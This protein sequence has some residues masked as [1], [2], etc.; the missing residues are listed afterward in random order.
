MDDFVPANLQHSRDEW[1]ARLVNILTPLLIEGVK[2]IFNEAW[3]MA[4]EN[5][6]AT[7]YLMT[8]QNLLCRVPK[9]NSEIVEEER[10]RIVE[11]SGCGYLEDLITCVHINQLKA[12][13]C[14]RV[15]N[16]QKKIDITIP[17]LDAFLHKAYIHVA[18]KVYMNVY[19][20][21][22]NV[23]PLTVQ[24]NNRELELIVHECLLATI[25]DSIPTEAIIRAYLDESIEHEEEVIIEPLVEKEPEKK[26]EPGDA[27]GGEGGEEK[28]EFEM[29]KE[30]GPPEML[31][32]IQ[33]I[34][35]TPVTTKLSFNDV[36]VAISEDN[37]KER[38]VAPKTIERL[39]EIS[40]ERHLQRK[41]EEANNA[42]D[43]D[44]DSSEPLPPIQ[45]HDTDMLDLSSMDITD[46][47][48][49]Q[50]PLTLDFD[51]L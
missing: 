36:D 20:F 44:D 32:V 40:A 27:E 24:K 34:D 43:E 46:L 33:N 7:K 48:G 4:I 39:E 14:V 10:K 25:R 8:F 3:K 35:T 47:N 26:A 42:D 29:P 2:S 21:E 41:L 12:L 37:L 45:I 13:T 28:E 49:S 50:S 6:E 30:E 1:C 5:E 22:K 9:W 19:L 18:R 17:K 38:I 11:R 15:G 31:P 23:S 51:I 16:K